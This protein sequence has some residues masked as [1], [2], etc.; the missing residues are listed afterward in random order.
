M[1]ISSVTATNTATA[2]A[3]GGSNL[4]D[5][6]GM[7]DRFLKLL[8]AQINNQDPLNPMDNAQMTSQMA[9]INT[10]S[11]IQQ[12]NQT[13]QGM[14]SQFASM[15]ML[16][17]TSLVGH[18]VLLP[19]A[20][21]ARDPTTGLASSAF[22]LGGNASQV[23]IDILSPIGDVLGTINSGAM[24]AGR[25]SFSWDASAYGNYTSLNYRITAVNGQQGVAATPYTTDKVLAVGASNGTVSVDLQSGTSV[26]YSSIT[27]IL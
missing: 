27:A 14:A 24:G 22:D 25:H 21:L 17:A 13:L 12:V 23:K 11:G 8:V 20:T 9:Q 15:Q 16:Q 7:Q 5:T 10:V 6:A 1:A 26:P 4:S 18:D 3:L 19:G 2:A